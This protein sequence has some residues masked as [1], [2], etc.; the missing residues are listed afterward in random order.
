MTT[1][2]NRQYDPLHVLTTAATFASEASNTLR[3]R[4]GGAPEKVWLQS[5][6]YPEYYLHTFHY[7]VTL[8]LLS[9]ACHFVCCK[10]VS[11]CD[12][13]CCRHSSAHC[14]D[15][16]AV[17]QQAQLGADLS[18]DLLWSTISVHPPFAGYDI[19]VV[20]NVSHAPISYRLLP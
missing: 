15:S 10:G 12:T 16:C 19:M 17:L 1:L 3:R 8:L 11:L 6:M 14:L 5:S 4:F 18:E 2:G 20:A 9:G 13:V 7:Q